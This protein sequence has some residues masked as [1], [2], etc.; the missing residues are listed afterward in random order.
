MC[1]GGDKPE[2]Y[3][4]YWK[5]GNQLHYNDMKCKLEPGN[6]T[7]PAW[8]QPSS[9]SFG[10]QRLRDI[11]D[12]LTD[13]CKKVDDVTLTILSVQDSHHPQAIESSVPP[14]NRLKWTAKDYLFFYLKEFRYL[15]H[16]DKMKGLYCRAWALEFSPNNPQMSRATKLVTIPL[17][18][19][20]QT[21]AKKILTDIQQSGIT[22]TEYRIC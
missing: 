10:C 20:D 8:S 14:E 1:L 21:L 17:D 7:C 19:S 18:L 16:S 12:H 6:D 5:I 13:D 9:E 4:Q 3:E 11:A 2:N 22:P 15:E